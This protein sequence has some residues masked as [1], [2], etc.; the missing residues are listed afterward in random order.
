VSINIDFLKWIKITDTLH[1]DPDAFLLA[2]QLQVA[3]LKILPTDIQKSCD[4]QDN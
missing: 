4:F 3:G 2:S 1:E